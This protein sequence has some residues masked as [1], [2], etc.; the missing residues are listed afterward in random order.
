MEIVAIKSGAA[1]SVNFEFDLDN[2]EKYLDDQLHLDCHLP[3]DPGSLIS[4]GISG[5]ACIAYSIQ[6]LTIEGK[7]GLTALFKPADWLLSLC[8][9][10]FRSKSL[11]TN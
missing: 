8:P 5:G 9:F 4:G 11:A 6:P 10:P 1:A 2:C 3:N 7:I